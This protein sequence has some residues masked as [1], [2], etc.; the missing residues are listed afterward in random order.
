[1]RGLP[2]PNLI[3]VNQQYASIEDHQLAAN[4]GTTIQEKQS[5]EQRQAA[6]SCHRYVTTTVEYYEYITPHTPCYNYESIFRPFP[7]AMSTTHIGNPQSCADYSNY[8]Q[9][10]LYV[11]GLSGGH[12]F[13]AT[14]CEQEPEIYAYRQQRREEPQCVH[15]EHESDREQVD[16]SPNVDKDTEH[17]TE[18]TDTSES[19]DTKPK[20]NKKNKNNIYQAEQGYI[21]EEPASEDGQE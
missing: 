4:I 14:E 5:R 7:A 11:I 1:M 8:L 3:A 18:T 12:I 2:N 20:Q 21:V 15:Y 10:E 19:R 17:K 6:M 13:M 16:Q 9:N